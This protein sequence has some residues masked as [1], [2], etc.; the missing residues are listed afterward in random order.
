[1][2]TVELNDT[3]RIRGTF[4]VWDDNENGDQIEDPTIVVYN[5][6]QDSSSGTLLETGTPTKEADGIYYYDWTPTV[7]GTYVITL[8]GTFTDEST[9]VISGTFYVET[10]PDSEG[11]PLLVDEVI[12]FAGEI[13]PLCLDPEELKSAF[14]DATDLEIAEALWIASIDVNNMLSVAEGSCPTNP[15]ALEHIKVSAA[16]A[17]SKTYGDGDGNEQGIT[18]GDFSAQYRSYPKAHVNRGNATTWCELAA[19]IRKEL[20]FTT[21]GARTFVHASDYYNPIPPREFRDVTQQRRSLKQGLLDGDPN[22]PPM[23]PTYIDLPR[24]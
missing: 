2:S 6:Y 1:M 22:C 18:L 19:A 10:V 16:C 23:Q 11:T 15:L 5:V 4:Y 3:K 21:V 24:S 7:V 14:P 8:V 13:E 12:T 17:L 9:D 20:Q